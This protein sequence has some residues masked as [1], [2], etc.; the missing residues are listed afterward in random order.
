MVVPPHAPHARAQDFSRSRIVMRIQAALLVCTALP[1]LGSCAGM[2]RPPNAGQPSVQGQ[3]MQRMLADVATVRSYVYGGSSQADAVE[4]ATELVS[5]SQRMADLFPPSEA[6]KDYVDMSPERAGNA[7]TA[8]RR[9]SER[10][11]SVVRTGD[12]A[13]TGTQLAQTEHDGCGACH[14]SKAR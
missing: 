7:P 3:S 6:W 13:T 10:L 14:L 2:N 5:W 1:L 8:M 9:A 4:A 12:R 11:L